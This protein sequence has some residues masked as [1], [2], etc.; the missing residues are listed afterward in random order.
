MKCLK[1]ELVSSAISPKVL[2]T[3]HWV[4]FGATNILQYSKRFRIALCPFITE[5]LKIICSQG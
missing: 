3:W 1:S 2:I 4:I 5:Y